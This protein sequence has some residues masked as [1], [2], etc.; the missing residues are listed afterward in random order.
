M[1]GNWQKNESEASDWKLKEQDGI[2]K[3]SYNGSN[4]YLESIVNY[5]GGIMLQKGDT[6][7]SFIPFARNSE[8]AFYY[9]RADKKVV[10]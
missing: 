6:W 3:F 7:G 4:L 5:D 8:G 10:N 2:Y 1:G 9:I